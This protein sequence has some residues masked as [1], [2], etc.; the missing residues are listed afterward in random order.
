ML[1]GDDHDPNYE[2]LSV[3]S[4]G[5]QQSQ[6]TSIPARIREIITTHLSTEDLTTQSTTTMANPSVDQLTEENRMLSL[7]LNR[8]EDL[9]ASSRAERDEVGIRYAAIS[10]RVST[11]YTS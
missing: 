5:S 7:E 3:R 6:S 10:E 2:P 1:R 11:D 9:L 4:S 8:V